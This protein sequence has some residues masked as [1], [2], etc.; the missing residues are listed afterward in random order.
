MRLV[1]TV[2]LAATLAVPAH[3][4]KPLCNLLTDPANDVRVVVPGAGAQPYVDSAVDIRSLDVVSDATRLGVTLRMGSVTVAD[5]GS[6]HTDLGTPYIEF[7]V[8]LTIASAG[9]EVVFHAQGPGDNAYGTAYLSP[10][11]FDVGRYVNDATYR[12]EEEQYFRYDVAKGVADAATGE[13]RMSATWT[14]L[15]KYGYVRAARDRATKIRVRVQDWWLAN[16]RNDLL[17]PGAARYDGAPRDDASTAGT[18]AFGAAT[19]T[20]PPAA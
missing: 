7:Y 1:G 19:C 13:I 12:Y 10:W 16:N 2:L 5:L 18:Y 3:A 17:D 20:A 15:K 6:T 9:R 11:M 14:D 8:V 4:A